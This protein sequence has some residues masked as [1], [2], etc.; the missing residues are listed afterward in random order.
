MIFIAFPAFLIGFRKKFDKPE[1]ILVAFAFA[2]LF[3]IPYLV[4]FTIFYG[5]MFKFYYFSVIFAS[6]FSSMIF[7]K[8][9][10]GQALKRI[11][12]LIIFTSWIA[13]SVIN[14]GWSYYNKNKA[15]DKADLTA[16][17]WI[18]ENTP[19]KS[20]FLTN[21]TVHTPVTQI[22]GR[23]RVLSY[24]NWPYSHGFNRGED[25]IFSRLTDV[26][27]FYGVANED[28]KIAILKKYSVDYVYLG[29]DERSKNPIIE[30]DLSEISVLELV[31]N[32][33]DV[34]IFKVGKNF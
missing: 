17:L 28:E 14:L 7:S 8:L 21:P 10:N 34:S 33:Q 1:N 25:N 24:V 15:Y 30:E 32:S 19:Q 23:L 22:A 31:Y 26:E 11:L 5:D 6:I 27:K 4:N 12:F 20:V 9:L 2:V 18:R 29:E 13:T 3:F 16:G